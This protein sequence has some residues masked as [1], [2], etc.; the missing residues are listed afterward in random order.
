MIRLPLPFLKKGSSYEFRVL[1]GTGFNE[2]FIECCNNANREAVHIARFGTFNYPTDY[3]DAVVEYYK[4]CGCKVVKWEQTRYND[5]F[6][7]HYT[8]P[9]KPNDPDKWY[10]EVYR[11]G[12]IIS[13]TTASLMATAVICILLFALFV[14]YFKA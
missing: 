2:H 11:P 9:T 5:L 14:W 6:D 1:L 10:R 4:A 8:L 3:R 13:K 7:L 12:I